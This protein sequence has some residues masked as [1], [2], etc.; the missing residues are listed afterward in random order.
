[1]IQNPAARSREPPRGDHPG[2]IIS[3]VGADN[4]EVQV[5]REKRRVMQW[6]AD[7]GRKNMI[8]WVT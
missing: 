5:I 7:D 8:W 3:P 1:V 2:S 4:V 6:L